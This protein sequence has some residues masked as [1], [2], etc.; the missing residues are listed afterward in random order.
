MDAPIHIRVVV[1]IVGLSEAALANRKEILD[2][3]K[4]NRTRIEFRVIREGPSSIES[5]YDEQLAG[6]EVVREV[7]RADKEGADAV[8][9]WC[10]DDPALD[11]AREVVRI[12]VVGPGAASL[13]VAAMLADRFT[14]ITVVEQLASSVW[15]HVQ[16]MGLG[17]R[18]SSVRAIDIPVLGIEDDGQETFL[19]MAREA[20]EAVREDGAQAIVLG[21][22]GMIN[23]SERLTTHLQ[24]NGMPIPVVNPAI[25][26]LKVAEMLVSLGLSQSKLSYAPPSQAP[27]P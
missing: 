13:Y 7:V 14:V 27:D 6:P 15:R 9:I 4:E 5:A 23:L 19:R 22:M 8:I 2:R 24:T 16:T 26:S 21:C 11:A 3:Y 20:E 1:P 10:A 12:P 25:A 18:L 17:G